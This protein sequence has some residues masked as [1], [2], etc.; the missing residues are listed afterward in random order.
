MCTFTTRAK[1]RGDDLGGAQGD[2]AD[3]KGR[4]CPADVNSP[5]HSSR[6][7]E[8]SGPT[9]ASTTRSS[10]VVPRTTWIFARWR[11]IQATTT[12]VADAGFT[13]W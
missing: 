5:Y 12:V 13:C 4:M 11:V 7:S 6:V 1:A 2:A 10:L 8:T 3:G 9:A